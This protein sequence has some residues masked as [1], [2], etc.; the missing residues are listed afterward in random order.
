MFSFSITLALCRLAPSFP[1]PPTHAAR[2]IVKVALLSLFHLSGKD[3]YKRKRKKK[4]KKRREKSN[5][6]EVDEKGREKEDR[7]RREGEGK[8]G[9][10]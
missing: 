1:T 7:S 3:L 4:S 2:Q 8:R 9:Q 5:R 10:K 6:T